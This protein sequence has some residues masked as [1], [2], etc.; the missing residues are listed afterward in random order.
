MARLK[1][2]DNYLPVS[3][4]VDST[5][6]DA[7]LPLKID[8]TTGRLLVSGTGAN[9]EYTEGDT[10]TTITGIVA[11]AE[12]ASDTIY[13]LK[14]DASGNLNVNVAA[15]SSASEQ[16]ADG[17]AVNAT[18]KGNL[19]LGTDGSYYQIISVDSDGNPQ[20]DILTLPA[21]TIA[22]SQTLDTVN[23]IT[24]VVHIDD[25]AGS[26]TVDG[27][28]SISGIVVVD[29]ELNTDDL[30]TGTGI[31]TQSIA[32]IA[33]P[34]SGGHTLWDG[35]VVLG[36]GSAAI[37]SVDVTTLPVLP[38]GT[39]TIGAV[40][41]AGVNYTAV[42]K[43]A[44]VNNSVA[45]SETTIWTPASGKTF[46]ITDILISSEISKDENVPIPTVQIYNDDGT[47]ETTFL[48]IALAQFS[49]YSANY[50]TPIKGLS[51]D[52]K[53]NFRIQEYSAWAASTAYDSA[54]RVIP[55]SANG[56]VY[57]STDNGTS[58]P[59][60]P[61]WP[62]TVGDTVDDNGGASALVTNHAYS[63]GDFL[64]PTTANGYY[65]KCTT[66]GTSAANE[67]TWPKI[68]GG[69]V[70]DNNSPAWAA[71]TA[72]AVGDMIVPTTANGYNYECTTA[73]TSGTAEPTWSTTVGD[74]T[75]DGSAVWTTRA[76]PVYTTYKLITWECES[77]KNVYITVNGYEE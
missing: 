5:N 36:A 33:I 45:N 23:T 8:P 77:P 37:G 59:T 40:K 30:D 41:D 26:L 3:G 76:Q 27:T 10:D 35:T 21:I 38:A 24:N 52:N 68:E 51:A 42:T 20:V 48:K 1:H 18:Y 12:G 32:G 57:L 69:T 4:G 73:G 58:S 17:T 11:M 74:T 47:T 54:K 7:I 28:V 60:E 72:Y 31:D 22:A 71:S 63:A 67:P 44:T 6:P 75:S 53:L 16:Y 25:N 2:D 55:T 14:V 39:N 70:T 15:G 64:I 13:P 34:G 66:N 9:T 46:V 65:Y 50:K 43:Y 56:Y 62:T 29:T 61:T 49:G 19:I